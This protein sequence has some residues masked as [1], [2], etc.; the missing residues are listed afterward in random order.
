MRTICGDTIVLLRE[1]K[2]L[3]WFFR[4]LVSE[5]LDSALCIPDGVVSG[6]SLLFSYLCSISSREFCCEPSTF[7]VTLPRS[8]CHFPTVCRARPVEPSRGVS[9]PGR[10]NLAGMFR[11]VVFGAGAAVGAIKCRCWRR[12]SGQRH[13][14]HLLCTN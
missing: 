11:A 7:A 1:K 5:G 14:S 13:L 2:Q 4:I 12:W 10:L 6:R 9:L 8:G 3:F